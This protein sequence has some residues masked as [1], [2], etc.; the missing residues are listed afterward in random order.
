MYPSM[1]VPLILLMLA[2]AVSAQH[3]RNPKSDIR[4]PLGMAAGQNPTL[5]AVVDRVRSAV[6][7]DQAM[8]FMRRV[9]STDRWFTF[10]KFQ[11]TADYLQSAMAGIGLKG[12]EVGQAPA[13]GVTQFGY[14]T[15][16]L[17]WDVKQARLEILDP[18]VVLA[19]YETVP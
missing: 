18:P 1:R 16:P 8:E 15:M 4:N 6:H 13:D 12:V 10:P 14:W 11:E 3:T 9:Y 5:E 17:A 19:D 2:A 7:P